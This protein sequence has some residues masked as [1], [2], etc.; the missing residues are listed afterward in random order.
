MKKRVTIRII[1]F[2]LSIFVL[3]IFDNSLQAQTKPAAKDSIPALGDSV[4]FISNT[5]LLQVAEIMRWVL[6]D[7]EFRK[8]DP[9]TQYSMLLENMN[10][11]FLNA[12]KK[13]EQKN[14]KNL[15]I[16]P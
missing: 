15:T 3:S 16:H 9:I 14:K 4:A 2:S 11:V 13:W 6:T 10:V 5:D 12:R 7:A 8:K 1:I